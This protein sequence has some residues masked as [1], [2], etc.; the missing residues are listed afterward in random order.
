VIDPLSPPF[1]R[2]RPSEGRTP[3]QTKDG[4]AGP[5][6]PEFRKTQLPAM[7]EDRTKTI[8]RTK[9]SSTKPNFRLWPKNFLTFSIPIQRSEASVSSQ[10]LRVL[11]PQRM[12]C[13]KRSWPLL[14]SGYDRRTLNLLNPDPTIGSL[15]QQPNSS[16]SDTSANVLSGTELTSSPAT[17]VVCHHQCDHLIPMTLE[18]ESQN[19]KHS[20]K[21]SA[22]KTRWLSAKNAMIP[23]KYRTILPRSYGKISEQF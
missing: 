20:P 13:L 23:N 6:W 4:S 18:M 2:I 11:I 19:K 8:R 15:R 14:T 16:G 5:K 9:S 17:L 10:I 21:L 3:R 22:S 7:T 1:N 12:C